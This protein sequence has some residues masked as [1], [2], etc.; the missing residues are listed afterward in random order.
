MSGALL[1][2]AALSSQDVYLTGNPEITL[3]KK[4]YKKYT[5][6]SVETVQVNFDGNT[7]NFGNSATITL[8]NT[9][10]LISR[11]VLVINLPEVQSTVKW[12]YVDRLGHAMIDNIK[13][14]IGSSQIDLQY[15]DWIDI[16]QRMN[17]DKSMDENYNIMIGNVTS[18]KK[19]DYTHSP[20]K[21]FIPLEFWTGKTTTSTFPICCS[22]QSSSPPTFQISVTLRNSIDI[23]N[24]FGQ[25]QPTNNELPIIS[26]GYLLVDY[27]YLETDE[28]NFF[29]INNHEY[30]IET[31]DSMTNTISSI[32]TNNALIFQKPTKYLV[33]Y[34]QLNRYSS[35]NAFLAWANDND[36]EKARQDFAKL[37][38]LITRAGLDVTDPNN[39]IINFYTDYVNIG[40][41][42]PMIEGGNSIF[43]TLASKV[44]GLILFAENINDEIVA[45]A[46]VDN[47]ILT[48][49]NITYED[50]SMTIAEFKEDPQT[51]D[52]QNNFMDIH[53]NNI[54]D[55]FNYANF[56]NRTDNPVIDSSFLL[57]G[58]NRFQ[59]RDGFFYN[60]LQPY[61]YFKNSPPDGINVYTFALHPDETQPSGLLNFN[62]LLD[63]SKSLNN[64]LGKYNNSSDDYLSFF[65]FGT[66]RIFALCQNYI[67]VSNIGE[68]EL[69]YL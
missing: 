44:D 32:E 9:G 1:Q 40:Q 68:T 35:R 25:T 56:I 2:L 36:W 29:K 15:K 21:I 46:T 34:V 24:Y 22:T 30:L 51:T 23:I 19:F 54:I 62:N 43:E 69:K 11:M 63:T 52:Q 59:E 65:N 66:I 7:A 50:M 18:L 42:P 17:K 53:T 28:L 3:F 4:V 61:Y 26:S 67:K 60:Y 57:G 38:W 27:I 31:V 49:N 47:V 16:Y 55:I 6:F 14:T 37:V 5:N 12:G 33:W 58:R 8:P 45:S 20:Y 10:D 41:V 64:K 48:K 13:V 39:P